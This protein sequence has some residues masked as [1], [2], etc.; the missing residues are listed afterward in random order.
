MYI[1]LQH[2]RKKQVHL[3]QIVVTLI[4][5]TPKGSLY[6]E[7]AVFHDLP[8]WKN[9]IFV[10]GYDESCFRMFFVSEFDMRR[11]SIDPVEKTQLIQY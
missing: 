10:V 4:D 9:I 7:D 6:R 8:G 2:H 3:G 11:F 5:R 1:Q